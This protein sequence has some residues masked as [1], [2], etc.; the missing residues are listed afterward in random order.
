MHELVQERIL[1][2]E[3]P[4]RDQSTDKIS[5]G[6]EHRNDDKTNTEVFETVTVSNLQAQDQPVGTLR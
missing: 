4:V 6:Y 3:L 1:N 2:R 5:T